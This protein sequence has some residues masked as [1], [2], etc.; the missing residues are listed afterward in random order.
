MK[1][2]LGWISFFILGLIGSLLAQD[3][4]TDTTK[5]VI[6]VP[7]KTTV[8]NEFSYSYGYFIAT[9]LKDQGL[10]EANELMAEEVLKGLREGLNM[11]SAKLVGYH[12]YLDERERRGIPAK[13]IEEAKKIAYSLGYSKI[14]TVCT[15]YNLD[16]SDFNYGF[17]KKGYMDVEND[18]KPKFT[19]KE[20][21]AKLGTYYQKKQIVLQERMLATRKVEAAKNLALGQKFLEKNA[22]KEGI[23]IT[24]S[25]LQYQVIKEGEGALITLDH[26]VVVHYTGTL[27]NG[28]VF[29][30]SADKRE[31]TIRSL[32]SVILGW[33]E[34]VQ[35][36]KKGSHYR[37]FIP[38]SLGYEEDNRLAVPPSSVLI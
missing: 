13:S 10:F 17:I 11:D 4:M 29:D 14:T 18:K 3:P 20:V 26:K 21:Y 25:G 2:T 24:A 1:R 38:E 35:L 8:I 12:E 7:N 31:R 15:F 36:M 30:C 32:S 27:I 6:K 5:K 28:R 22:K 19:E 16:K 33:Q 9:D 34:G 23:K 37:L